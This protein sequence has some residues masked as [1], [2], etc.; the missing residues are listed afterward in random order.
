MFDYPTR[1]SVWDIEDYTKINHRIAKG[2]SSIIHAKE[3][4][5]EGHYTCPDGRCQGVHKGEKM[6]NFSGVIP[7]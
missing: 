4:K 5:H 7:S 6:D 1:D 2:G 3:P